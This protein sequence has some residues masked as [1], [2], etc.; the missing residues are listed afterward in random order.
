M[1]QSDEDAIKEIRERWAGGAILTEPCG[2]IE[3][4]GMR[5]GGQ[6]DHVKAE[7]LKKAIQDIWTLL[8]ILR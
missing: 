2:V 7:T 5:I 4:D 1:P 8:E 6:N 3:L